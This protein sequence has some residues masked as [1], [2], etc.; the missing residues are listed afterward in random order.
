MVEPVGR[1]FRAPR[2]I[3]GRRW[4]SVG[5]MTLVILVA[6]G[7]LSCWFLLYALTEW[8]QDLR[9]KPGTTGETKKLI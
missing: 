3:L 2:D 6:I 8:I 4:V 9:R 7:F 1:I 5:A